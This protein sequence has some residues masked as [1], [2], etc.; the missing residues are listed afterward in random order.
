MFHGCFA[1][2]TST[3]ALVSHLYCF[4]RASPVFCEVLYQLLVSLRVSSLSFLLL[5]T[6]QPDTNMLRLS[7]LLFHVN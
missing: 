1:M 2:T 6:S 5:D 3:E 4:S 7:Y